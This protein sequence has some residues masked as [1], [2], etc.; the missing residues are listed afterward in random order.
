INTEE[1][2][3]LRET[4]LSE[5]KT[6]GKFY[7]VK[8][9]FSVVNIESL[10]NAQLATHPLV[11]SINGPLTAGDKTEITASAVQLTGYKY[12]SFGSSKQPA[13]EVDYQTCPVS[14]ASP[15]V[16]IKFS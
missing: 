8:E 2:F 5:R 4:S 9:D 6:T 11:C 3:K 1:D 10:I 15:D 7:I 13:I 16:V 14:A 12:T